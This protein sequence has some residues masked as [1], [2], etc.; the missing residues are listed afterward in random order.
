MVWP[1]RSSS[2]SG[3]R[4]AEA[5][6]D[7]LASDGDADYVD[8]LAASMTDG[9]SGISEDAARCAAKGMVGIVGLDTFEELGSPED[10]VG[11]ASAIDSLVLTEEQARQVY[12]TFDDCI[13]ARDY[14]LASFA[15]GDM[16]P[17]AADCAADALTDDLVETFYLGIFQAED[18]PAYVE[19]TEGLLE[20]LLPCSVL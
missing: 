19:A 15:A 3:Q 13:G 17:E 7:E 9:I 16:S 10:L 12:E 18:S 1:S 8:A 14:L 6:D 4:R 5:G 11:E 2:R 20:A